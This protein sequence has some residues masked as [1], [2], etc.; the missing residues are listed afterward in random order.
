M[1]WEI[2][3]TSK[4]CSHNLFGNPPTFFNL[5]GGVSDQVVWGYLANN[6]DMYSPYISGAQRLP[7]GNTLMCAGEEGN[8]V[9]VTMSGE[10]VWNYISPVT[11]QGIVTTYKGGQ[12]NSVFR[13]SRYGPDYPGLAG[14]D[15]TPGG[16]ITESTLEGALDSFRDSKMGFDGDDN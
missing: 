6:S 4:T 13:I 3:S 14:Q 9:E 8:F 1:L 7:N 12:N 11:N 16:P 15:L 5:V 2:M 10:V